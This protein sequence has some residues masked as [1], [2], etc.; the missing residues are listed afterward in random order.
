MLCVLPADR[1]GQWEGH[2]MQ[3]WT[4]RVATMAAIVILAS[5]AAFGGAAQASHGFSDVDD[6]HPFHDEIG[7]IADAGIT[8]GYDD[9]TFRPGEAVTRQ[10]MAAFLTRASAQAHARTDSV[11]LTPAQP[12]VI[13]DMATMSSPVATGSTWVLAS[14]DVAFATPHEASCPCELGVRLSDGSTVSEQVRTLLS[15]SPG[16]AGASFVHVGANQMFVQAGGTERT[17]RVVLDLSDLDVPVVD[18]TIS[19]SAVVVPFGSSAAL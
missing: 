6:E 4:E 12:T 9:G 7:A 10:A 1:A 3:R 16:E 18:A 15:D 19:W 5:L 13:V 14:V 11:S 2:P 8:T 17:H